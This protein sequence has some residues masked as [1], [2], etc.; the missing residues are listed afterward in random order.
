ML[1]IPSCS[2]SRRIIGI[3]MQFAAQH[4]TNG[5]I[6]PTR[7]GSFFT[8]ALRLN[9]VVKAPPVAH[10]YDVPTI[11]IQRNS[12]KYLMMKGLYFPTYVILVRTLV[13]SDILF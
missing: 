6:L 3:L 5:T 1:S 12:S 7:G 13:F 4:A 9:A 8:M 11:K 10:T 2:S